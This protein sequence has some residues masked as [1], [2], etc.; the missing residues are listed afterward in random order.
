MDVYTDPQLVEAV[1]SSISGDLVCSSWCNSMMHWVCTGLTE[2]NL[3]EKVAYLKMETSSARKEGVH[4]DKTWANALAFIGCHRA[5][6]HP[7]FVANE[8]GTRSSYQVWGLWGVC[9]EKGWAV[10]W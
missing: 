7:L 1:V 3:R 5:L 4:G 10:S 2:E 9:G 6:Q 8:T